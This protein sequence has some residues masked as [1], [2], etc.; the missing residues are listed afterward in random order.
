MFNFLKKTFCIN[1]AANITEK[2]DKGAKNA[3]V[4]ALTMSGSMNVVSVIK[5]EFS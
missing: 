4:T 3:G 2:C 5:G 1:R